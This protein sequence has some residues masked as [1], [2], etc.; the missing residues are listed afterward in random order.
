MTPRTALETV[1][2]IWVRPLPS[3]HF[4][5][6]IASSLPPW[7][8]PLGMLPSYAYE[9]FGQ[10]C[11]S[12]GAIIQ[13]IRRALTPAQCATLA[14]CHLARVT[15]NPLLY[16]WNCHCQSCGKRNDSTYEIC[17][18]NVSCSSLD[19]EPWR[20]RGRVDPGL[21]SRLLRL[22]SRDHAFCAEPRIMA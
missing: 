20:G 11:P 21:L 18:P 3:I 22:E 9:S 19:P 12:L 14:A 5:T 8:S 2:I 17:A 6:V 4:K 1:N 7:P 13:S 16:T 15:K 10:G